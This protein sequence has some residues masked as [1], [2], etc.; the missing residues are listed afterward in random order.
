MPM[1]GIR[2][3]ETP[4]RNH[5]APVVFNRC[6]DRKHKPWIRAKGLGRDLGGEVGELARQQR[7]LRIHGV[8]ADA[9]F[10]H[11]P[12]I[13]DGELGD[14]VIGCEDGATREGLGVEGDASG[15]EAKEEVAIARRSS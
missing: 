6:C 11:V 7:M 2:T 3:G 1:A 12:L 4:A 5:C 13:V 14:Q 9:R 8:M 15:D 10:V